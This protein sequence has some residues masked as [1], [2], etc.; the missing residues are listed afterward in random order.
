MSTAVSFSSKRTS[1]LKRTTSLL[2]ACPSLQQVFPL[3]LSTLSRSTLKLLLDAIS[4]PVVSLHTN[5]QVA[6]QQHL[7]DYL[8]KQYAINNHVWQHW[9]CRN[10][11]CEPLDL[12]KNITSS[13]LIIII[14]V[15]GPY[16]IC[17]DLSITDIECSFKTDITVFS[18][19]INAFNAPSNEL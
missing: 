9:G 10:Y 8:R 4:W 2:W 13:R 11:H 17:K 14:F 5:A 12:A 7:R 6:V 18:Q 19:T 15:L 3:F 16:I 1:L